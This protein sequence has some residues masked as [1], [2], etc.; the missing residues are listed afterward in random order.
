MISRSVDG[1]PNITKIILSLEYQVFLD[2]LEELHFMLSVWNLVAPPF[3]FNRTGLS[4]SNGMEEM[5]HLQRSGKKG[6]S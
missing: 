4:Q 3:S 1:A 2:E 6:G 5:L